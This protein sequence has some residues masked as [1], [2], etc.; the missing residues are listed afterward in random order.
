MYNFIF[1]Y[2]NWFK[3]RRG[4][5]VC[6]LWTHK[7]QTPALLQGHKKNA[8]IL[9]TSELPSLKAGIKTLFGF[10]KNLRFYL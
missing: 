8:L 9:K 1:Y 6:F 4:A 10:S 2:F 7:K 3:N 5:G